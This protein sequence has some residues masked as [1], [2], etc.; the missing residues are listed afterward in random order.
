MAMNL[1]AQ[2]VPVRKLHHL[3]V[4]VRNLAASLAWYKKMFG[5]EP[6]FSAGGAGPDVDRAV[7][8]EGVLI[9]AAFLQIG[10]VYLEM[11]EFQQ[12]KGADFA[13]RNCD[14]GAVHIALDVPDIH[15]AYRFL[16][17]NGV[18]FSNEPVYIGEGELEGHWFAYFRD[19]DNIQFE[20]FQPPAPA[21]GPEL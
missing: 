3:G 1:G 2:T 7:Q 4:P 6:L 5:L 20:L 13:L 9:D 12:P 15:E 10:D 16:T 14:V 11:L 21:G 18:V 8:L 17:A 19:P